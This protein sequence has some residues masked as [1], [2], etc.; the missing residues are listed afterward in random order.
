MAKFL[1][2][3]AISYHLE[4]L[5]KNASER[6]VII[7]PFLKFNDRVRE[8]LE[9]K[10]RLKI[11]I[12]IVYGK[13]DLHPNETN[14]LKS[15]EYVRCSF[16]KHLHAKCYLSERAAIITSM[17]LYEFSQINNNEMGVLIDRVEDKELYA[18]AYAE[19]NR[20][21]RISDQVKLSVEVIEAE[22]VQAIVLESPGPVDAGKQISTTQLAKLR[23]I[24]SKAMFAQLLEKGYVVREN[25]S[26]ELTSNGAAAGGQIRESPRFGRYITWPETLSV[27]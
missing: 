10:D 13:S 22:L 7:S 2:T 24:S 25:D 5:I 21:I 11:D 12:R 9:D 1:N 19:S 16:C 17:N 8:L 14:W 18:D 6:L 27:K 15:L 3:S 4:E 20:L 23:G 26:W